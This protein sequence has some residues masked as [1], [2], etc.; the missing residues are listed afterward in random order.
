MKL[1]SFCNL[2]FFHCLLIFH[3]NFVIKSE[4]FLK[5]ALEVE[6][7]TSLSSSAWVLPQR[8]SVSSTPAS[9]VI[10]RFVNSSVRP[11]LPLHQLQ[12][13]SSSSASSASASLVV[14]FCVIILP[15]IVF[16]PEDVFGTDSV[17][18][19]FSVLVSV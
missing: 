8:S 12:R 16:I 14:N 15:V 6:V 7:L 2:T 17:Q 13:P 10:F 18:I 3:Y 4:V 5:I 9:V 1:V 19:P 11:H